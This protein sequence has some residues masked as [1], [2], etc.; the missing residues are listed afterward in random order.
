MDTL[1]FDPAAEA[2]RDAVLADLEAR[3]ER[4]RCAEEAARDRIIASLELSLQQLTDLEAQGLPTDRTACITRLAVKSVP[5]C[6]AC[7]EALRKGTG[8]TGSAAVRLATL[9]TPGAMV[10]DRDGDAIMTG[11]LEPG[12]PVLVS[13]WNHEAATGLSAPVGT[14]MLEESGDALLGWPQF[15]DSYDGRATCARV[16]SEKPDWSVTYRVLEQRAPT[17]HERAQGCKRVILRWEIS[18]ISPVSKGAG[19]ATGTTSCCCGAC[20]TTGEKQRDAQIAAM[21]RTLRGIDAA[22]VAEIQAAERRRDAVIAGLERTLA[23]AEREAR[24]AGGLDV[25]DP[26]RVA[27]DELANRLLKKVAADVD[28]WGGWDPD[29]DDPPIT[30]W[31][32]WTL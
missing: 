25:D 18:E 10:F 24:Y 13:A 12:T 27:L 8:W 19:V 29:A 11:A 14:A 2:Q 23:A 20:D 4:S 17:A 28:D 21:E 1:T 30:S 3:A 32:R 26:R 15:D 9:S 5:G 22:E 31:P 7:H 16:L 6:Q